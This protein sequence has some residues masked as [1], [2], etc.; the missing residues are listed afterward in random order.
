MSVNY[1]TSSLKTSVDVKE[2]YFQTAKQAGESPGKFALNFIR[3]GWSACCQINGRR[4]EP[5]YY[6]HDLGG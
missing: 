6:N 3:L 4:C 2:D 1:K 5:R